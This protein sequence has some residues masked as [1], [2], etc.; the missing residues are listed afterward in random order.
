MFYRKRKKK[1]NKS[2][3]SAKFTVMAFEKSLQVGLDRGSNIQ[4]KIVNFERVRAASDN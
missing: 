1:A 2:S 3:D 4:K